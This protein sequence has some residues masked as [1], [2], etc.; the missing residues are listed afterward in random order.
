[1]KIL[2]RHSICFHPLNPSLKRQE[3]NNTQF[4]VRTQLESLEKKELRIR[5]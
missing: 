1:M 3:S 2:L 5:L 4:P